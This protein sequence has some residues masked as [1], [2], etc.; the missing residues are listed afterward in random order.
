[1]RV[2]DVEFKHVVDLIARINVGAHSFEAA[3]PRHEHEW[4][5]WESVKLPADTVL[6]PG[7]VTP[8]NV[9]VE[10]PELVAMRIERFAG[11]VGRENVIAG[12]DCG[13]MSTATT[14]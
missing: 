9:M 11:I 10:H 3:N 12:V 14:L 6:I 13:V 4:R 8:S 7:V 2:H 5:L 1:P